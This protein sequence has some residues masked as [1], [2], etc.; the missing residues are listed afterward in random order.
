MD[1]YV[2]PRQAHALAD[3]DQDQTGPASFTARHPTPGATTDD[4]LSMRLRH[5]S[6]VKYTRKVKQAARAVIGDTP[7]YTKIP[8]ISRDFVPKRGT[9][10][11]IYSTFARRMEDTG[12][13]RPARTATAFDI[14]MA[15][16]RF[17]GKI[18]KYDLLETVEQEMAKSDLLLE[19][20]DLHPV[21]GS[22]LGEDEYCMSRV[23]A[24]LAGD[25]LPIYVECNALGK[26]LLTLGQYIQHRKKKRPKKPTLVGKDPQREAEVFD[27][28]LSKSEEAFPRQ[29]SFEEFELYIKD[30]VPRD[31]TLN[32]LNLRNDT[33]RQMQPAFITNVSLASKLKKP[34]VKTSTWLIATTASSITAIHRDS[35]GQCTWVRPI[36]GT[37]VWYI[38]VHDLA[39]G[40]HTESP[41]TATFVDPSEPYTAIKLI[42]ARDADGK[43]TGVGSCW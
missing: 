8:P 23:D 11:E 39:H 20:V 27:G 16:I 22:S 3:V 25:Y 30:A 4:K 37:K 24:L 43:S 2:S 42:P 15:K 35:V 14:I 34:V 26:D 36:M 40:A 38:P 28:G 7:E 13:I 10:D 19:T 33:T 31:T 6:T 18:R 12:V 17:S 5:A 21:I 9:Y 41:W 32:F 1:R 29:T